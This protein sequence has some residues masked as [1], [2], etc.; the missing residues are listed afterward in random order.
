MAEMIIAYLKKEADK[1]VVKRA[2]N[3]DRYFTSKRYKIIHSK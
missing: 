2:K 3:I 1:E